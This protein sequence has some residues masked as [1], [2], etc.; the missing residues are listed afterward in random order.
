MLRFGQ[1]MMCTI[2][3]MLIILVVVISIITFITA[4]IAIIILCVVSQEIYLEGV[5]IFY[6]F[7]IHTARKDT[8]GQN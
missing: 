3:I 2:V 8:L 5:S 6:P 7:P 1:I 4:I